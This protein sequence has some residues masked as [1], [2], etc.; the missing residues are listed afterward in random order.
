MQETDAHE[1]SE[2]EEY[3][4]STKIRLKYGLGYMQKRKQEAI[5]CVYKIQNA[6]TARKVLS[7]KINTILPLDK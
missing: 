5:L 3:N 1:L 6:N 4:S 2:T 7:C